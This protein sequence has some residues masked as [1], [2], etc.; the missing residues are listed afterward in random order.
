MKRQKLQGN[1]SNESVEP[2]EL[3]T[4]LADQ[5]GPNET[6]YISWDHPDTPRTMR[7]S[8]IPDPNP[9]L[10]PQLTASGKDSEKSLYL[11][12]K[13]SPKD[14]SPAGYSFSIPPKSATRSQKS[15]SAQTDKFSSPF[16]QVS[17]SSNGQDSSSYHSVSPKTD[18]KTFK[19]PPKHPDQHSPE[20]AAQLSAGGNH[21]INHPSPPVKS[22]PVKSPPV[23]S[24]NP[25]SGYPTTNP[26]RGTTKESNS[27]DQVDHPTGL[28]EMLNIPTSPCKTP[29]I[30]ITSVGGS[31]RDL[32]N[33]CAG[34]Q[35]LF[36][37]KRKTVTPEDTDHRLSSALPPRGLK[38]GCDILNATPLNLLTTDVK[39]PFLT[40]TLV[41]EGGKS[42]RE[43]WVTPSER[44]S[45]KN[46]RKCSET[47]P[48]GRP[49]ALNF[50]EM[51][52][53]DSEARL[54]KVMFI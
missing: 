32:D 2:A 7:T 14:D 49:L 47:T 5:A 21:K 35:K 36:L 28:L 4:H 1:V 25:F 51:S 34:Q 17:V 8:E 6:T 20:N 54:V 3:V 26:F 53:R 40:H 46:D 39:D 44:N 24:T 10:T 37:G 41:T 48:Y 45:S 18:M 12:V 9:S 52:G 22:P 11:S 13:G 38:D 31:Y 43:V 29:A 16:S 27:G 19:T 42:Q 50:E 33:E 30:K 15:S 23:K